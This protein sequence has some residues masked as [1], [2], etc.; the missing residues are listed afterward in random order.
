MLC[1]Q[2]VAA[3]SNWHV[4]S[5]SAGTWHSAAVVLVPPLKEGGW[6]YTWGSG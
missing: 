6:V 5:V 4:M 1:S 3:L 2:P